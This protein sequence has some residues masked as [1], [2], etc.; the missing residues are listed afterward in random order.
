MFVQVFLCWRLPIDYR[1]VHPALIIMKLIYK[2][3]ENKDFALV[4]ITGKR[5]VRSGQRVLIGISRKAPV[6]LADEDVV[7][8][9]HEAGLV[10]GHEKADEMATLA[11]L[12]LSRMY[13]AIEFDLPNVDAFF[14][15]RRQAKGKSMTLFVHH[16]DEGICVA[17]K[18]HNDEVM[19][20]RTAAYGYKGWR[21]DVTDND[22]LISLLKLMA[23]LEDAETRTVSGS[24]KLPAG[25]HA[26]DLVRRVT[27]EEDCT[28]TD[29]Y[30]QAGNK[31]YGSAK[32]PNKLV[33]DTILLLL[34]QH[35]KLVDIYKDRFSV[36]HSNDT[37]TCEGCGNLFAR[38]GASWKTICYDCWKA[39][40][41][42]QKK[43]Y[44]QGE[45]AET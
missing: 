34:D 41:D 2:Q 26:F 40:K 6:P 25:G 18:Y 13:K 23:S 15:G 43:K 20:F 12:I 4:Q 28:I 16:D 39:G 42:A 31:L 17:C 11:Q 24:T 30:I 5:E 3:V 21:F 29:E 35:K 27:N 36:K 22:E 7:F 33:G 38:N 37:A 32:Y 19:P 10:V 1:K 14:E 44:L 8:S 9:V 45:T